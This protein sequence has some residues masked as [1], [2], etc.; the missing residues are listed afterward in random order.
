MIAYLSGQV[1]E[2]APGRVV[3]EVQGVG[4]ELFI[5]VSTFS[6]IPAPG[7][8]AA[9]L[10][11]THVRE[12]ALQLFGFASPLEKA[13]FE[14]LLAVNGVGPKLALAVLS[15]VPAPDLA[16][17]IS[18]SDL[19]RLTAIPGVGKKTAER[20]CVDLR[21]KLGGLV[22]APAES[23]AP[24]PA[25]AEVLSALINLGYARGLAEKALAQA[26]GASSVSFE[27]LFKHCLQ[28]IGGG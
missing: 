5:P 28:I 16:A 9:L 15:G 10:V 22:T 12:D 19:A 21:D 4:Y 24:L 8:A 11:H 25:S 2:R 13:L 18:G 6:R 1:R 3:L 7:Q 17:A 14:K 20:I 23:T 27:E 26:G